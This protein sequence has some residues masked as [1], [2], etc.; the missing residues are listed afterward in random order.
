MKG[1]YGKTALVTGASRGI[2]KQTAISLSEYG[3]SVIVHYSK[4]REN[5]E[6]VSRAVR[7]NGAEAFIMQGNLSD[8]RTPEILNSQISDLG[9]KLSYI[10]NNAGI[11]RGSSLFYTTDEEWLESLRIDLISP[12]QIVKLLSKEIKKTGGGA[13]VNVSSILGHRPDTYGYTYQAAKAALIHITKSL[14]IQFAP[15]IRVNAVSPGF[16]MTDMNREGWSDSEFKVQ[17]ESQTPLNR[18]GSTDDIAQTICFLLSDLASFI[19]GQ[20]ICVDGGKGL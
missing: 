17:V 12:V 20:N 19:T 10:V 4:N 18:W 14:A 15:D 11:Y 16:I 7:N 9:I 8:P 2:G 3:C 6:D 13:I 1:L 5:A